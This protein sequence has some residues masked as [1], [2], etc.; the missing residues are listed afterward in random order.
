[1]L[2]HSYSAVLTGILYIKQLHICEKVRILAAGD[3]IFV[4][5]MLTF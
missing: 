5:D 1:M 3:F 4:F 2:Q